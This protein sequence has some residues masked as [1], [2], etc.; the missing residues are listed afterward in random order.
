MALLV[1]RGGHFH[2][3]ALLAQS[4]YVFLIRLSLD[5][6]RDRARLEGI[7]DEY[8]PVCQE[9]AD[10]RVSSGNQ[11][12]VGILRVSCHLHHLWNSEQ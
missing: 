8:K 12:K 11:G 3:I 1:V 4:S 9:G 5:A 2:L 10:L 7:R 6:R